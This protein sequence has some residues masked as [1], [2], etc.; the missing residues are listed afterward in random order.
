[1]AVFS[2]GKRHCDDISTSHQQEKCSRAANSPPQKDEL[3]GAAE[4]QKLAIQF[5]EA[6]VLRRIEPLGVADE[7][8]R[9]GLEVFWGWL[10]SG[11]E[12]NGCLWRHRRAAGLV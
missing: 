6:G 1:M 4:A 10:I 9:V 7:K 11:D 5:E 8:E 12:L 3:A 2:Q